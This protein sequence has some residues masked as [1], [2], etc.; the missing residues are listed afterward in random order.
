MHPILVALLAAVLFGASTPASKALLDG[1]HP[2]QL[3]GWLYLGAAVGVLPGLRGGWTGLTRRDS[4]TLRKLAGAVLFGGVLGPIA[5]LLGL[6]LASATSVSLWLNLELVA[7]ALLGYFVF[8]DHLGRGGWIAV[9]GVVGSGVLLSIGEGTGG[10]WPA[11]LVALACICWGLDNHLTALIDG[12]RPAQTTFLKGLVAGGV[13]LG[14]AAGL[15]AGWPGAG[16]VLSAVAVGTLAYGVSIMLYITAAQ[17]LGATRAQ[18]VFATAPFFG[19]FLSWLVLG[20]AVGGMQ[21]IAAGLLAVSLALLFGDQH[22]HE[23]THEALEHDHRH[24]HDDGHHTHTH[25]GLPAG[26]EHAHAHRHERLT[27]RHPHWPDLHHRHRH[28]PKRQPAD[29]TS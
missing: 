2:V 27:H 19:A 7:T 8:R 25:P 22:A 20:E 17:N 12:I 28:G 9:A 26:H 5:L 29:S 16:P 13:N 24:R 21:L 10:G 15:G 14:L 3:A 18:L 6:G 4:P 23:H 11:L 1:I